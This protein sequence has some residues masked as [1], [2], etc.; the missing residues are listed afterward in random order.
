MQNIFPPVPFSEPNEHGVFMSAVKHTI[1]QH[2]NAKAEVRLARSPAGYHWGYDY[3][4]PNNGGCG[5]PFTCR[6]HP[7][8]YEAETAALEC[9]K[10]FFSRSFD[11]N[12]EKDHAKKALAAIDKLLNTHRN[13]ALSEVLAEIA[14]L[15]AQLKKAA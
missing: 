6:H 7:T 14:A 1:Y 11:T 4:M 2:K 12:Q 13:T 8:Q 3:L 15:K 5:G 9:F 10:R